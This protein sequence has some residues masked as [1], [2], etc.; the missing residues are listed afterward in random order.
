MRKAIVL[1]LIAIPLL[2]LTASPASR[3]QAPGQ[4]LWVSVLVAPQSASDSAA[5]DQYFVG[6]VYRQTV[7]VLQRRAGLIDAAYQAQLQA[8]PGVIEVLS[9]ADVPAPP[10]PDLAHTFP[11]DSTNLNS[12]APNSRSVQQ[13]TSWFENDT[14][15]VR[16]T[17]QTLNLTGT[18]VTIG[19]I[20]SGVDFG[21]PALNGRYAVQAPTS[22]GA[23][24]YVG[25]PIAFDDRSLLMYLSQPTS[26]SNWGWYVNASHTLTGTGAFTFT[27]PS[28]ATVYTAPNA[29]VSGRYYWGYHPDEAL[30]SAPVL[31]ADTVVS[32]TYDAAFMD[33]NT[34][35]VFETKLTQAR[36][37]GALDLNGDNAA[38]VSAGMMYWISDGVNPLPGSLGVYGPN[39]P[40]P[41]AGRLVAFMIDSLYQS[42]GGHGTECA[43]TAVGNDGGVFTPEPRVTSF[44]TTTYGPLVQGPAP[45]AKIIAV[46]NV[47]A[48]G[49]LD[50][51]YLFMFLGYDGVPHTG[52]EP[53]IVSLSYGNSA[54]DNDGY[55]WESRYITYLTRYFE[56]QTGAGAAPL[57]IHSA[58]NGGYG[59]GTLI[60][61]NADVALTVG[62]STQYG[63]I[64]AWGI[65]ETISAPNR[66][67]YGD[68][69][70]ISDRGP[71]TDG[72]RGVNL[73]A[74]GH[75]GT[76]AYP[77]NSSHNGARAYVH[78]TGTS[79]SSP[80][81]AGMGALTAQAFKRSH[82]RF[83]SY[84]ELR[85]LLI[86]SGRDLG[87][88]VMS[89]GAGQANAF[90]AAQTALGDYG[91]SIDPPLITEARL[92]AGNVATHTLT[93]NNVSPVAITATVRAQQLIEVAHYTAT[94]DT[95]TDTATN[96]N[97]GVPDYALNISQWVTAHPDADLMVVRLTTPFE[98]FDTV[99]PTPPSFRNLWRLMVYNWWDLDT[100][101]AWWTDTNANGRVDWPGEIDNRDE[102][103]RFDYGHLNSTQ[104][105][106]RV[107]RPYIRSVGAGSGG[108]WVGAAHFTRSAG[109]NHTP[110]AIDV[111]FYRHAPWLEVSLSADTMLIEPHQVVQVTTTLAA[112]GAYGLH[113][114]AII[115]ADQGRVDLNPAF[116]PYEMSV[117]VSW[118]VAPDL[119]AG[120]TITDQA[121][122]GFSW[123]GRGEEGDWHYYNFQI[124]QP[125]DGGIIVAHSQWSDYPT[126]LDTIIFGPT[127][128]TFSAV[129]PQWFG[130]YTLDRIGGSTRAGLRPSWN[131]QTVTGGTEEWASVPA[132][133]GQFVAAQEAVLLGGHQ[134]SVPFT[135]SLGLMYIEPYPL[136]VDPVCGDTCLITATLRSSLDVNSALSATH[137]FGWF[138]PQRYPAQTVLPSQNQVYSVFLDAA[139][140]ELDA[141]VFN[142]LDAEHLDVALYNDNGSLPGQFD[143]LDWLLTINDRH[144]SDKELHLHTLAAGQYWV[145]VTARET[146]PDGA[147]YD[148][149]IRPVPSQLDNGLALIDAPA[150]ISA[151]QPYTFT[152]KATRPITAGQRGLIEVG[153]SPLNGTLEV[154]I[155]VEALTDVWITTTTPD[156]VVPGEPFTYT[157]TFGNRGSSDAHAVWITTTVSANA[158][159]LF[160]AGQFWPILAVGEEH[161]WTLSTTLEA[162]VIAP[163]ITFTTRSSGQEFDVQRGDNQQTTTRVVQ[164]RTDLWISTIGPAEPIAGAP[165][166]YTVVY[167]NR[168]P[169]TAYNVFITDTLPIGVASTEPPLH[170]V[171][172]LLPGDTYTW[173][174]NALAESGISEGWSLTNTVKIDAPSLDPIVVNNV[175]QTGGTIRTVADLWVKTYGPTYARGGETV[176]YITLFGNYGPSDAHNAWLFD[177]IPSG[178][179]VYAPMARHFEVVTSGALDA[180]VITGTVELT[181]SASITLSNELYIL[182]NDFDP[183]TENNVSNWTFV[184]PYQNFLPLIFRP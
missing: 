184:V 132:R 123:S 2:T 107:G 73:V 4:T 16:E 76:G 163:A 171:D 154:P 150:T 45:D 62:A 68:V 65:S 121:V 21:N 90:R 11:A 135:T 63:T 51:D 114:G 80:V 10:Q 1:W 67:N 13:P 66:V 140:Y 31:V 180:W 9:A 152:L 58:G 133:A 104:Q 75:A 38:D 94:L 26:T 84:T 145:V 97:Y 101:G 91:L 71:A 181:S 162:G 151:G 136:R 85:E 49:A 178:V 92:P 28:R 82:G 36:P 99:P 52:D 61:P 120:A 169:S 138:Q 33:L 72:V 64:N 43:S 50:A 146:A 77:V 176:T 111:I 78:W 155:H 100:N 108:V 15:G 139:V 160:E 172:S 105:E 17:W 119:A 113:S 156:T 148:L 159:D 126:D 60:G 147:T 57:F 5:I 128:D 34:D 116:H 177:Q 164:A 124:D 19:L 98:H 12:P 8:A 175:D 48:G 110:L 18:G 55:D 93:I 23:Q 14:Q 166:S 149:E 158:T 144:A 69:V 59:A 179:T 174:I 106:V 70:S 6:P 167:G 183:L 74:N 44:Y 53:Q 47:Y 39:V 142:T 117:P 118:Q 137:L 141:E 27:L 24:A 54:I 41:T 122:G 86:N 29:S 143:P 32:G 3:A 20:D 129:A 95:L 115:I 131:F 109:D 173:T 25:W 112:S 46:G 87:H 81:V 37:V 7:G 42:G 35:G 170:H 103:L 102:W 83:P 161:V 22:D 157:V 153:P 89:Q 30:G 125:P 134:S 182:A 79:R 130:T 40:I 88:E 127:N 56:E 165:I 96:Y 168:G